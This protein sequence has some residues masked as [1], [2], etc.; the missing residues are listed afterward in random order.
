MLIRLLQRPVRPLVV[1]MVCL[2]PAAF[3][4]IVP[5]PISFSLF[6]AVFAAVM[7]IWF[8]RMTCGRGILV[9]QRD[10]FDVL[11]TLFLSYCLV[12]S[13]FLA[14]P[15]VQF[16][17]YLRYLGVFFSL[18]LYYPLLNNINHDGQVAIL[19]KSLICISSI[20]CLIVLGYNIQAG[21]WGRVESGLYFSTLYIYVTILLIGLW[22]LKSNWV[23][24]SLLYPFLFIHLARYVV[25]ARRSPLFSLFLGIFFLIACGLIF[26]RWSRKR[27]NVFGRSS[28]R[29]VYMTLILLLLM[30]APLIMAFFSGSMGLASLDQMISSYQRRISATALSR[31]LNVRLE[32]FKEALH[33]EHQN[34]FLGAGLGTVYDLKTSEDLHSLYVFLYA[35]L[36]I[37]GLLIFLS[38][39][40]R[41]CWLGIKTGRSTFVRD[42]MVLSVVISIATFFYFSYFSFSARGTE[43][44]AMLVLSLSAAIQVYLYNKKRRSER[45]YYLLKRSIH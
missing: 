3:H 28:M 7:G 24:P 43:F 42:D 4:N 25:D 6:A 26:I 38:L 39:I 11:L 34:H 36:G 5:K 37:P 21:R 8:A 30:S 20:I 14:T 9:P 1:L 18:L 29:R 35:Q 40:A 33:S 41:T 45:T 2:I 13:A 44:E 12:H 10:P 23:R 31:A 19:T 27:F 17:E 16:I 15:H 32:D 22:F